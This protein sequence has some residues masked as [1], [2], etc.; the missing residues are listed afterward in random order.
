MTE[1][2]SVVLVHGGAAGAWTWHL[3]VDGLREQGIDAHALDLPSCVASDNSIDAHDDARFLRDA[4]DG[5]GRPVVILGNSYGGFVMSEAACDH[6][7]VRRLVYMAAVMPKPGE[8]LMGIIGSIESD[9]TASIEVLADGRIV[10]DPDGD[11]ESSYHQ[12]SAEEQ[13]FIRERIG[14]PMSLG[15]DPE[16][17]LSRVAWESIP[18][19]YVVCS[20]DRALP[21][22]VQRSWA[23]E[24]ATEVVEWPTDHAPQHSQP[25]LVVELLARFASEI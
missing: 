23:K 1:A 13:A 5:I 19:T 2:A 8:T 4:I 20:D 6:P 25:Q 21:P 24:R 17:S 9:A 10:F 22:D 3:V 12:S 16:L 18:S 14:R 7:N 11:L 15:P